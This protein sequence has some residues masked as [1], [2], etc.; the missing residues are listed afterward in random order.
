MLLITITSITPLGNDR[1]TME[2]QFLLSKGVP[3]DQVDA[4]LEKLNA[5]KGLEAGPAVLSLLW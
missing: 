1:K 2:H 4:V 3:V 5:E